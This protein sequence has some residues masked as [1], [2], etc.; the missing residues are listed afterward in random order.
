MEVTGDGGEIT[1]VIILVRRLIKSFMSNYSRTR[2]KVYEEFHRA[3]E[4]D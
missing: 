4:L 2:V 3:D 1:G